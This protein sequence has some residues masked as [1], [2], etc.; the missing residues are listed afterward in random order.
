MPKTSRFHRS[1]QRSTLVVVALALIAAIVT[2][3]L[4]RGPWYDEFYT[5]WVTRP[6]AGLAVLVPAWLRDN[7]PPLFYA[8]AW[9]ANGIGPTIE[10][11][12]MVN[13][14][15]LA[16]A[17]VALLALFRHDRHVRGTGW[18]YA[19]G[20]ASSW[21]A[22][23]RAAELRSYDL[24]LLATAV[25]L[26]ALEAFVRPGAVMPSRRSFFALSGVLAVSWAIHLVTT[27]ILGCVA[28]AFGLR[29]ILARDRRGTFRLIA[30]ALLAALPFLATMAL[31]AGTMVSNTRVFWIAPGFNAARWA[32]EN[33][34]VEAMTAN[35]PL[36]VLA[37]AGSAGLA[38][39]TLRQRRLSRTGSLIVTLL[40]G[41]ALALVVL[42]ALHSVRPLVLNRYL[43]ALTPIV[44]LI[45]A[46]AA[47]EFTKR[48]PILPALLIEG[49]VLVA[50][51]LAIEG[52]LQ[53][54]LAL[55]SW[56]GT[57]SLIARVV[58]DCPTTT[59]HVDPRWNAITR[60]M[61]PIDNRDVLVFAYRFVAAQHGFALEPEASRTMSPHCPT[62][63]WTEHVADQHP[64]A[65]LVA[66]G[67]RQSGYRVHTARM[68]RIG[69]GWVLLAFPK[70]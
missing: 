57:A 28:I 37:L 42:V 60:D 44:L 9:L 47:S 43:V 8:L 48:L 56:N 16:P 63:F 22:I 31:M 49:A 4:K 12:R 2:A 29:L 58:H 20:L 61:P 24:S 55:P 66:E 59:I 50:T 23:N 38:F 21:P 27:V 17:L 52:N 41:L 36:L 33:E 7:H 18:F 69:D 34:L 35:R 1:F 65:S 62:L 46:S 64:S 13:L 3:M 25:L 67:L 45:L 11:R 54:T 19:L 51:L 26:V 14:L 39:D 70:G 30:A 68:V 53:R 40:T 5:A 32:I 15:L 10:Q 6:G